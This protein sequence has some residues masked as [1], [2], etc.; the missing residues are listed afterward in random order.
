MAAK[1][2]RFK[3]RWAGEFP[4]DMLRYD[5]CFPERESEGS[6]VIER[7]FRE[8]GGP[9]EVSLIT[10]REGGHITPDRWASFGARVSKPPEAL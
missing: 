9:Y 10:M 6:S 4:I 8:G 5:C 7:S 3:V 1:L 2:Y